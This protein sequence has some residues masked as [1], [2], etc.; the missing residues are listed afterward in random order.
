VAFGSFANAVYRGDIGLNVLDS[1]SFSALHP[2]FLLECQAEFFATKVRPFYLTSISVPWSMLPMALPT[3]SPLKPET[4]LLP[5][6]VHCLLKLPPVK[7]EEIVPVCLISPTVPASSELFLYCFL[8]YHLL[9][10]WI[11]YSDFGFVNLRP[12]RHCFVS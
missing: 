3:K 8:Q 9:L 1:R 2:G 10:K 11:L 6:S 4:S 5:C 7:V 12:I